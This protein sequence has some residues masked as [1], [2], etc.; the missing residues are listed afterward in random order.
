MP[1][2]SSLPIRTQPRPAEHRVERRPQFMRE[3]GEEFLFRAIG[4]AELVSAPAEIVLEPLP[5]G[6]VA[7][8]HGEPAGLAVG[9][10]HDRHQHQR[11]ECTAAAAH[12]ECFTFEPPRRRGQP[13]VLGREPGITLGGDIEGGG[14][15]ADDLVA[16]IA[17]H[18]CGSRIPADDLTVGRQHAD[19]VVVH[20]VEED[21][22]ALFLLAQPLGLIVHLGVERDDPAVGLLHLGLQL[23]QGASKVCVLLGQCGSLQLRRIGNARSRGL[24]CDG[25]RRQGHGEQERKTTVPSAPP[26]TDRP[27][28]SVLRW[29]CGEWLSGRRPA[30]APR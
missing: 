21:A 4:G 2:A 12:A 25:E 24:R 28:P 10:R 15:P 14:V 3:R 19:G 20:A 6:N 23:Q 17:E 27:A 7:H 9:A 30:R 29:R 8:H 11:I 5:L 1:A 22:H 26:T 18:A 16:G 13:Q